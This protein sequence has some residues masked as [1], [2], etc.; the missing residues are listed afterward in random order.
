MAVDPSSTINTFSENLPIKS[1]IIREM[2]FQGYE[3]K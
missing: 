1:S 2:W 3:E